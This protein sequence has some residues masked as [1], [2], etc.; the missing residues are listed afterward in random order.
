MESGRFT[1]FSENGPFGNPGIL[2]RD[3]GHGSSTPLTPDRDPQGNQDW[4]PEGIGDARHQAGLHSICF[5]GPSSGIVREIVVRIFF[6]PEKT[7]LHPDDG[8]PG[9]RKCRKKIRPG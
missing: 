6:D 2:R 7:G 8:S 5:S 1:R 4:H 9:L 3:R